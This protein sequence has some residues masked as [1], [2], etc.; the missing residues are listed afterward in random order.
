[1][2]GYPLAGRSGVPG[3]IY[4]VSASQ[5]SLEVEAIKAHD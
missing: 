1:V 2:I 4:S 5:G 3:L